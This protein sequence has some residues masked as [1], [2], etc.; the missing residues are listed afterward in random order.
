MVLAIAS[1]ERSSSEMC[2]FV[3]GCAT[4]VSEPLMR[5]TAGADTLPGV[6]AAATAVVCQWDKIGSKRSRWLAGR[7]AG[8][9]QLT[10]P[11]GPLTVGRPSLSG[12]NLVPKAPFCFFGA[13]NEWRRPLASSVSPLPPPPPTP[14]PLDKD[15]QLTGGSR[16]S[17]FT[18]AATFGSVP[19]VI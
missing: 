1:H 7:P 6:V 18:S 16:S 2:H 9:L 3:G 12:Q 4:I 19:L 13:N 14:P 17:K 10:K 15:T 11:S 8:R 5:P